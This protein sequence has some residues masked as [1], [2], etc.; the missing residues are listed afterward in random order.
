MWH[1]DPFAKTASGFQCESGGIV[2][3]SWEKT[4]DCVTRFTKGTIS[5]TASKSGTMVPTTVTV[6]STDAMNAYA[7]AI[8]IADF[9]TKASL[10]RMLSHIAEY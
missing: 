9:S 7:I 3:Y 5:V 8:Q 1:V 6:V 10:P 4:L 2:E